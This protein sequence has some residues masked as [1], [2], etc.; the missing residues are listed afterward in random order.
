MTALFGFTKHLS[1]PFIH[2]IKHHTSRSTSE[3]S[4]LVSARAVSP[5]GIRNYFSL[6]YGV[7]K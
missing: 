5:A 2:S 3:I 6:K 4:S 1:H 7:E